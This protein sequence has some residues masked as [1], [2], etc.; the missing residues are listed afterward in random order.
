MP[1]VNNDTHIELNVPI[2]ED[3]VFFSYTYPY[4]VSDKN[5]FLESIE[6]DHRVE[7]NIIGQAE[8]SSDVPEWARSIEM[9][10]IQHEA[11]DITKTPVWI[12]ARIHPGEV[13]PSF[14][15]E[16]FVE[17]LL[18]SDSLEARW[19]LD[20]CIFYIVPMVNPSGVYLGNYR[21]NAGSENLEAIWCYSPE[22]GDK[23]PFPEVDAIKT[24]LDFINNDTH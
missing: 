11:G 19:L 22:L 7:I 16:G 23:S 15:V 12:H 13:P 24:I 3:Q 20:H 1:A 18:E 17:Y 10:T 21:T 2:D 4:T 6:N 9:L 14:M 8:E 5:R